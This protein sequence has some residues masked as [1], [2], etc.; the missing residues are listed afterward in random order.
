MTAVLSRLGETTSGLSGWRALVAAAVAGVATAL[1]FAPF[2]AFPALLLGFAALV[3]L[4]D[5]C[6]AG[7]KPVRRAALIGWGFG[8]GQFAAGMHWIFYP[9]LVDPIEH[10]WQIPFVAIL[11]PGGLALFAA[12]A[13]AAAMAV[14]RPGAPRIFA[15]SACYAAAEWLRG[16]VL[17]GLPWNLPAY[18]WGA[19]LAILQSAALFGAYGLSLLTILFGCA[20]AE[21]C[22]RPGRIGLPAAMALLFALLWLGGALRLGASPTTFVAGVQLRLV[23]P[24]IPQDEKYVRDLVPRNWQRLMALSLRD[25]PTQPTVIVWPE[26]APPVLLQRAPDALDQI[27]VLTNT[28][29]VLLTGNQRLVVDAAGHRRYFN[30]LYVFGHGGELRA[31]YDKFHLVPFGEYLPLEPLLKALGI[32]KLVGFPGSFTAGDGPHTVEVPGAP[33]AG[34]L[35]CYEILFPA[36]VVGQ[37]RPGWL[38]N[39]TDDSWFGPWAGPRQHLLAARVRAVEEGLPIARA[40]NTGISAVVDPFGRILAELDLGQAGVVDSPLPESLAPTPYARLGDSGF[41][42]LLLLCT[43]FSWTGMRR[44]RPVC[45]SHVN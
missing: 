11:F 32:T 41:A 40:A 37:P 36:A 27:A 5:G 1:G 45:L 10:A 16:H 29:K 24:D 43:A 31:T 12:A 38:V 20:L 33:R 15:L 3:L 13:C 23:Q 28:K 30:S 22:A 44:Q 6:A 39:V 19:S 2:N 9:F 42:L 17:S 14:W 18:G 34:P 35:I 26:A 4:L 21:V 8:F 7:P 25:A